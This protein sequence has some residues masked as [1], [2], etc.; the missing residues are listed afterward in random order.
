MTPV[1]SSQGEA[2]EEMTKFVFPEFASVD[3]AVER[4]QTINGTTSL[5]KLAGANCIA[6]S[7]SVNACEPCCWTGKPSYNWTQLLT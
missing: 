3:K 1:Q 7:P 5:Q 6:R 4:E 2:F